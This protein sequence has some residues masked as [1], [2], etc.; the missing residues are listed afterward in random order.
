MPCGHL[1]LF[2]EK[3][4]L[5]YLRGVMLLSILIIILAGCSSRQ[6]EQV[7]PET[8]EIELQEQQ[9]INVEISVNEEF[10]KDNHLAISGTTNLPTDME[11]MLTVTSEEGYNAQSKAYVMNGLFQSEWFTSNGQ[12]LPNGKY[13]VKI[14]SPT[15]NIQPQNVKDVIGEQGANLSG[16]LVSEDEI[17]G[18]TIVYSYEFS[19]GEP[20]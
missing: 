12:G 10:N 11:L 5:K 4:Y 15:A 2:K 17:W 18:K 19:S 16:P 7:K 13:S 20:R 1:N 14:T 9:L 6:S 3:L 8:K